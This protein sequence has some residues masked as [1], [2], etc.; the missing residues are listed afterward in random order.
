[1]VNDGQQREE[2]KAYA[3]VTGPAWQKL[4]KQEG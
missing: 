1:M 3:N 4:S 2:E